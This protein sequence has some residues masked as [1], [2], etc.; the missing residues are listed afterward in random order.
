MSDLLLAPFLAADPINISDYVSY[1]F[2][3]KQLLLG[4]V[5]AVWLVLNLWM[6]Q[7]TKA[8]ANLLMM[9]GAGVLTLTYVMRAFTWD[10]PGTF[11]ELAAVV[12]LTA[13][14]FLSVRPMVEAQLAKLREKLHN[15]TSHKKDGPP[16]A[17]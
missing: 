16:P 7:K 12:V 5:W 8:Q 2:Q 10:A 3:F 17:K 9:V 14:F 1:P 13:G 15:V 6:W 4:L 11:I